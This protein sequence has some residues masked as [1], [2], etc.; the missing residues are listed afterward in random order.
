MPIIEPV[1]RPPSERSSFLLQI[2]TGCSS[3][4]CTFCGA[5]QGKE[6]RI[7]DEQEIYDDI[8]ERA[9]VY[10]L[11][12]KVFLLDGDALA[13]DND[14]LARILRKLN[15][16]LP[17][18]R[19]VSSY[20]NGYNITFRSDAQ[21]KELSDNKLNLVYIGLESGNQAILTGCR[22]KS[23]AEEMIQA[24]IRVQ[25]AGIKASVIVLLGLGGRD[26]SHAHV[27]DTIKAINEMQPHF[28][29]FLCLML[30][31]GTPLYSDVKNRTFEELKPRELL[32]ES[33]EI[34]KGLEL[35]KTIFRSNH[36]SNYL[37][38]EG[39]M[40]RDKGR[41]LSI[42]EQAINGKINLKPEIFRGL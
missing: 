31:P 2:T 17:C 16:S 8:K 1:I 40:P 18:I 33:Y 4:H 20:A 11:T 34:I 6:F 21:I 36:A 9:A 42:L 38:L 32:V 26:H 25:K 3:N 29:S 37:S 24:V 27:R 14:R 22:K 13:V 30:I 7:K 28:L 23:T 41:L 10:P 19:R 39:V 15:E 35:E 12:R 5:Y